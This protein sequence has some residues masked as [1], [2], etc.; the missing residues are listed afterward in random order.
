MELSLSLL[1]LKSAPS[2]WPLGMAGMEWQAQV[3]HSLNFTRGCKLKAA[4]NVQ[5]VR[6]ESL[7]SVGFLRAC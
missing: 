2:G 3:H 6:T 4:H 7:L 5:G 1:L